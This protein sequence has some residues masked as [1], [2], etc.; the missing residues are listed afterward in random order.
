MKAATYILSR[1]G[2]AGLTTNK[3]AERAGVNIASLYQYF[4]SKEALL[5]ELLRRHS[6]ET[7]AA[8]LKILMAHRGTG[9]EAT[10]RTLVSAGIAAHAV[11]PKLHQVFAR[12]GARLGIEPIQTDI[13]SQMFAEWRLLLEGV[14]LSGRNQEL[15]L[16]IAL[17]AA[18]AVIHNALV[19]R[20]EDAA[21][22][23]LVD[24][25]TRL[26]T[27]YLRRS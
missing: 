11:D 12:E 18:H 17:T 22:P 3:V 26:I 10:V 24:E 6:A 14:P 5:A 20:P 8:T 25:L 16:W 4:P 15:S 27:R 1:E 2:Y 23:E 7:R 19:E 9:L 21:S 13:D